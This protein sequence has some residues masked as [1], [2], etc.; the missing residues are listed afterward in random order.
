MFRVKPSS[1]LAP[2]RLMAPSGFSVCSYISHEPVRLIKQQWTDVNVYKFSVEHYIRDWLSRAILSP[3]SSIILT[4]KL[5]RACVSESCR[6]KSFCVLTGQ[7]IFHRNILNK[8]FM[9]VSFRRQRR[10]NRVHSA[11][12]VMHS[13]RLLK[14]VSYIIPFLETHESWLFKGPCVVRNE[15]EP[16][17]KVTQC[18]W[19]MSPI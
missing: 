15:W 8:L 5:I 17:G 10:G 3:C 4:Q 12:T 6:G 14:W 18:H 16:Y 7:G 19:L 9:F 1:L 2:V 11:S 13:W